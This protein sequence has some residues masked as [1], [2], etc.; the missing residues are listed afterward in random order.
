MSICQICNKEFSDR[1]LTYH[2]THSHKIDK[3][4]YYDTYLKQP[5]DGICKNCGKSTKFLGNK[6]A[7]Y[8]CSICTCLDKYGVEYNLQIPDVKAKTHTKE[9]HQKSANNRNYEELLQ[10]GRQT[11]LE[12][13]GDENYHNVDKSK[14]T[15][16][17]KYGNANYNNRDKAKQTSL[18]RYGTINPMQSIGKETFRQHNLE[19]YGVGS[20]FQVPEVREK[21]KQT[22]LKRYNDE[23]YNNREKA[24]QT[25]IDKYGVENPIQNKEIQK[26]ALSHIR[27]KSENIIVESLKSSYSKE[28]N[29]NIRKILGRYELDIY[30]PDINLAIEYNGIRYHSIEMGKPKDRILQKSL[31]CREIGIRLIHIYEFEDLDEQIELLKSLI[32]GEDRYNKEDFNKNNLILKVPE[33][34]IIFKNDSYTV[35]GAGKLF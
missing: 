8:C 27:S 4:S 3:K 7:T 10:K 11:K 25:C 26:R 19:Q 35:Y 33:P 23:N 9:A 20:I 34:E 5:N 17:I 31:M 15:K 32:L 28:I 6:Y 24:K 22:K 1:G 2:I 14:E 29:T 18:E 16:L 13:Y 30:L 21:S 12:K